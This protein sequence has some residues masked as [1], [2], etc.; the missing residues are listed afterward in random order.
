MDQHLRHSF[1]R[2]AK[3]QCNKA[4]RTKEE[5]YTPIDEDECFVVPE[6]VFEVP[7]EEWEDNQEDERGGEK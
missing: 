2:P 3:L 7:E 6:G 1:V 4:K 5:C